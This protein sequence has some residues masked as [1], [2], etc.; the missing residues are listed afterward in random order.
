MT[1]KRKEIF[2][3]TLSSLRTE[4]GTHPFLRDVWYGVLNC[5]QALNRE[6]FQP[7]DRVRVTVELIG[8]KDGR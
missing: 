5:H 8:E 6:M 4:T 3:S 2:E 1:K 7:G